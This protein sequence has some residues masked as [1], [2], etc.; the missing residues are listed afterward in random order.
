ML[1]YKAR[2]RHGQVESQTHI[3]TTMIFKPVNL[4]VGFVTTL[5]KQRFLVL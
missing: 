3:A 2:K 1:G 4:L 5:S